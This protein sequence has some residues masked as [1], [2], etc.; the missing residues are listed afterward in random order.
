LSRDKGQYSEA[1]PILTKLAAIRRKTLGENNPSVARTL[2]ELGECFYWEAKDDQ[3]ISIL[4]QALE[5]DRRA[6][7]DYG[8]GDR[9]YL[10]LTLER[11]GD[12]DE[13]QQLLQESVD[14]NRRNPGIYSQ[15]YAVSLSNL[16]S[17][18]IDR[19]DLSGAESK[20][21][22]SLAIRRKILGPG[23][24]D[25]MYS[26]NNLGYVLLERGDWK[27]AEPYIK[28][29]LDISL[30]RLGAD[31]PRVATEMN[32]WARVLQAKGNYVEARKNFQQALN[33]IQHSNSPVTWPAA[34]ITANLGLLYFDW[35]NYPAAEKYARQALEMR[36]SL[37]GEQTPAFASSLIEVAEDRVFQNDPAGAEPLFRR[38]LKVRRQR[39]PSGHPAII[40]AEIRLGES[41]L[42]QDKAKE[43]SPL[44]SDAIS[45][46]RASPFPLPVWQLGEANSAYGAC[47]KDVGREREGD[48]LL[49]ESRAALVS[50]PRPAFRTQASDRIRFHGN[51]K[52]LRP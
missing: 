30:L 49:R 4:R 43:A 25:L 44:L 39:L 24:P 9:N 47:L 34:Q 50:D 3:A 1:E 45:S 36:R 12:F 19:G 27:P 21:R 2:G 6:G 40:M 42:A 46:T 52:A 22:E 16:G 41:L 17:A 35:A 10:A 20:L 13:A 18:L 32:N 31:H 8:A 15:D 14:I 33:I 28:E 29:A 7:P 23:H 11:K 26:L 37:G 38:A 5:I 48:I 51:A